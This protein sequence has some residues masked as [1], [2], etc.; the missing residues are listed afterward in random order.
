MLLSGLLGKAEIVF[1]NYSRWLRSVVC[2]LLRASCDRPDAVT[3]ERRV[4][5]PPVP[6]NETLD[7]TEARLQSNPFKLGLFQVYPAP[8]FSCNPCLRRFDGMH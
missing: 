6:P 1:E 7:E 3:S 5:G 2:S 8:P 4:A